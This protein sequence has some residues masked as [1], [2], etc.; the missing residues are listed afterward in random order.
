M[1]TNM[2][3]S[4]PG[5]PPTR[6]QLG[7]AFLHAIG[8]GTAF[9]ALSVPSPDA[10]RLPPKGSSKT[11]NATNKTSKIGQHQMPDTDNNPDTD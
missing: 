6:P 2:P 4:S 8:S 3:E 1:S 11:N 10:S 7:K 9:E 5:M